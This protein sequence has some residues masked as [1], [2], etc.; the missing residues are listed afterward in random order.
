MIWPKKG[1]KILIHITTQMNPDDT[2]GEESQSQKDHVS[3]DSVYVN[4]LE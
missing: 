3:C 4:Y 2:L 1:N